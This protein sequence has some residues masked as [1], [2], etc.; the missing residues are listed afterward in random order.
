MSVRRS[1]SRR[2]SA[3]CA[4]STAATRGS[5]SRRAPRSL[6]GP[7]PTE[8]AR[9]R[10]PPRSRPTAGSRRRG[11]ARARRA[12]SPR[13]RPRPPE[14]H[15]LLLR[16]GER[17]LIA[18]ADTERVRASHRRLRREVWKVVPCEY[19][20]CCAGRTVHGT[21]T[22]DRRGRWLTIR[23]GSWSTPASSSTRS[24]RCST[25]AGTPGTWC[26]P[27]ATRCVKGEG[28][29]AVV[30][31]GFNYAEFGKVLAD[32]YGVSDW[33]LR[34]TTV[35]GRIGIDPAE[36]DTMVL[37]HNH[38][39]HAGGVEAFPN[40]HVYIQERE[41]SNYLWAQGLPDRLQWLTTATDPDLMLWLVNRM[42][43]SKLTLLG[44][45]TE[46]LPGR[47]G[48][49]RARHPHGRIA[50]RHDRER[51]RRALAARRRQ[52]LRLRELHRQDGDGVFI[53]IGLAF[54]SMER[55]MLTMEEMWQYVEREVTR[56]VPFHEQNLWETFPS[57]VFDDTLH[58]AE[59]SLAP[60]E[61]SRI[62]RRQRG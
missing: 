59:L 49:P 41:V 28:H 14:L 30:D 24:A 5:R 29:L 17:R 38:F 54:G 10:T 45:D 15:E 60:G 25:A 21:H 40:A 39:D 6:L 33:Q 23:S 37:T 46:I 56:I 27:T 35:L 2:A 50:V 20:P 58:V 19:V 32:T 12:A 48:D 9:A 34:T 53:P 44:G 7:S 13:A 4:S 42:K 51:A 31:T 57:R 52:L 62:R 43:Q 36:V 16:A 55:C 11:A 18:A 8:A 47:A 3:S 22:S 61:P 1:P 26:C